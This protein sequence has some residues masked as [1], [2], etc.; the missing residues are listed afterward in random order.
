MR[1][2][3]SLASGNHKVAV[4]DYQILDSRDASSWPWALKLYFAILKVAFLS[5][6][7]DETGSLEKTKSAL[8]A[9]HQV[10]EDR[11]E[12]KPESAFVVHSNI[13]EV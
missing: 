3:W 9:L 7:S 8:K 5:Y 12:N 10:F 4:P 13:F 11:L 2:Q 6:F 1:L